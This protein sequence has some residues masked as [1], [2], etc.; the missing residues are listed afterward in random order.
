MSKRLG[1]LL[2]IIAIAVLAGVLWWSKRDRDPASVTKQAANG[3]SATPAA[4]TRD[5]DAAPARLVVAVS[6]TNGPIRGATVRLANKSRDTFTLQTGGDGVAT[7]EPLEPGTWS[8][9]ASAEGHEPAALPAREV[10]AGE[11]V[12][13]ELAL[14]GGGRTLTG[15]VTDVSGGPIGGA[16]I[17]AAKLGAL[18]QPVDAIASTVTGS[19]GRYSLSVAEGQLLAAASAPSYSPQ[20]RYVEVGASGGT[21]SF[22][23][24]PGGVIEGVVLDES[25]RKPVAGAIVE[26]R[27]DEPAMMLGERARQ[28]ATTGG[29]GRF[30]LAGLRP[31]GYDLT[32]EKQALMSRTPTTIGLGVAEEVADVQLVIARAPAIRGMAVDDRGAPV[33]GITILVFGRGAPGRDSEATSDAKGEFVLEG[34]QPG[35]YGLIGRSGEYLSAGDTAVEVDT[36]DVVGVKVNVKRG[37]A[38]KG[39]VEPR[40]VC[41]LENEVP[42]DMMNGPMMMTF[43]SKTTGV[44]GSFDLG[45]A[46]STTY[47]ITARCA[48]GAQGTKRVTVS[49]G[50]PDVIVEVTAGAS[51][52]G[53]VV[54]GTGKPIAAL[55]VM[56]SRMNATERTTIVNGMITSGVQAVT[57]MQGAFELRGLAAGRYR[58]GVLERGRPLPIK[59][60]GDPVTLAAKDNKTGVVLAVDRPDGTIRGVVTGPDGKPVADAW[61][62]IHVGI[63]ELLAQQADREGPGSRMVSVEMH[64]DDAA[65][66]TGALSPVLTDASGAFQLTGLARI[67]VTVIAE[68]QGGKLRGKATQVTP[69]ATIKI[70]TLG[71]S[72]LRGTVRGAGSA[73]RWFTVELEGPMTERRTFANGDGTFSFARVEAGNY[74]VRV[75]SPAGTGVARVQVAAATPATVELSLVANAIV[76]GKL[77]DASGKPLSGLPVV[78]IPDANDGKL[79]VRIEGAPQT[80]GPDGSF[81]VEAKAGLSAFLVMTPPTPTF[82]KG[83]S[84]EAGKTLDLGA[85]TV[86]NTPHGG[87]GGP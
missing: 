69:D 63:E 52:A 31:G 84:L 68:A 45:P 36:K 19:D 55:S 81:R 3:S 1:I 66:E 86:E 39:H 77:V 18:A 7:S 74:L 83:L 85:I 30:R 28:R 2:A 12:R 23:L 80:S 56:A 57:N 16:R 33:P 72:E 37:L 4:A 8:I 47:E 82:R 42:E 65:G 13:L 53:R 5:G 34:I 79:S 71:L 27:R 50:M 43:Q 54:D 44:D 11:T 9:S 76:I 25:D 58:L 32:A 14:V 49:A 26:A 60:G 38:L 35:R 59:S 48:S 40:Q 10:R 29:D 22:Q 6:G 75:T 46:Q 21:A 87:S 67:P 41:E 24:V 78:V 64:G 17:D 73:P 20:S 15:V 62:S 70:Q 51:I 61:V